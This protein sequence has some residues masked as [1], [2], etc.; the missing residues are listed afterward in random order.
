[1]KLIIVGC[2]RVGSELAMGAA[3]EGHYVVVIDS[4]EKAFE[5]LSD[6]DQ[7]RTIIGSA[8]ERAVL[9]SADIQ[10]A[11]GLAAV[12]SSDAVNFVVARMASANFGIKNVVAR[13]IDPERLPSFQ[14]HGIQ[15]VASSSWGARRIRHLM[16]HPGFI[17]LAS[18][19]HDEISLAEIRAEEDWQGKPLSE[20]TEE[21]DLA[22]CAL[23]RGGKA[24]IP[25]PEEHLQA[26]DLLVV[27][28][29]T[30]DLEK[31][32]FHLTRGEEH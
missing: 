13:V 3:A 12:T 18:V 23:V 21:F 10:S 29:H 28:L 27:S 22:I 7:I 31:M 5:R 19:G 16:T 20:L 4:H 32:K 9:D 26:G 11:D 1:M 6:F 25:A 17:P 14:A 15:A 24:S 2:G 8:L 30:E